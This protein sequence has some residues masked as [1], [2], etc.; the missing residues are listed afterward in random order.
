MKIFHYSFNNNYTGSGKTHFIK[1]QLQ[2]DFHSG[3]KIHNIDE[4]FTR[5]ECIKTF[6]NL[7]R[8][9]FDVAIYLNISLILSKVHAVFNMYSM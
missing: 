6:R 4:S 5:K 8:E 3:Y 7:S 1:K 2:S 9:E